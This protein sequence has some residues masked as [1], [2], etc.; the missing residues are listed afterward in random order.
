MQRQLDAKRLGRLTGAG[1]FAES[2]KL[3]LE[4]CWKESGIL[5]CDSVQLAEH[6]GK[7]FWAWGDTNLPNYPLGI[8]HTSSA[9]TT[10]SPLKLF[11]P[12]VRLT[13]N[14]FRDDKENPR[15]VAKM[16]GDGPTWLIGYVSLPD[17]EGQ[18]RLCAHYTK[19]RGF[20]TA[21]E[22]GLCV[23]DETTDSFKQHKV[24]WAKESGGG[25]RPPK[26]EPTGH[27]VFWEDSDGERWVLFGDP[28][29]HIKCKA[30][31]ESWSDPNSW[32]KLDAQPSVRAAGS[33]EEIRPHRGSVVWSGFLKKWVCV[34]VA[35][36]WKALCAGRGLVRGSEGTDWTVAECSQGRDPRQLLLLQPAHPVGTGAAGFAVPPFRGH[37]LRHL[38]RSACADRTLQLQPGALQA[39][40]ASY[41]LIIR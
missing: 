36:G 32:I 8:F 28:F 20:L 24:L 5:G 31:V 29:P 14:Y 7:L 22:T 2:Q 10:I 4:Q 27:P 34:F 38:C 13:F 1:L 12:P 25:A 17:E 37:L 9:T 33:G 23:W 6:G 39:R 15:G 16:P 3:G 11:Q 19:I 35:E 18:Q 40:P 30:T 26:L 41:P 21:Y